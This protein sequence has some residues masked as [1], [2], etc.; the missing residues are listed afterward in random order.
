MQIYGNQNVFTDSSDDFPDTWLFLLHP[1]GFKWKTSALCPDFL[2]LFSIFG[3]L[4]ASMKIKIPI[5][6]SSQKTVYPEILTEPDF[7]TRSR[8]LALI[9]SLYLL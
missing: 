9:F 7:E 6:L 1:C 3:F 5:S 2:D 8:L 4:P